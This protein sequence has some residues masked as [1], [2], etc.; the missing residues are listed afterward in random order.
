MQNI[1]NRADAKVRQL[2]QYFTGFPC[3]NGHLTY[4]YTSSGACSGC[5]RANNNPVHDQSTIE[6]KEAKAQLVQVRLR[7]H[8]VDRE[9]LAA[10]AW[11]LVVMRYPALTMGDV[12]PRLLPKDKVGGTGLYAFYCHDEDVPQLRSIAAGMVSAQRVD[13][14]AVRRRVFGAAADVPVAPVPE[15]ARVPQPGDFDYK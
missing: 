8:D 1:I 10:A 12:D 3:K 13:V 9:A 14:V 5:I 11:A 2:S 4:R 15:W 6:R 7:C